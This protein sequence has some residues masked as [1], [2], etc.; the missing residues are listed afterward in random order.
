MLITTRPPRYP[1]NRFVGP[2]AAFDFNG[3]CLAEADAIS[4]AGCLAIRIMHMSAACSLEVGCSL[5]AVTSSLA[6]FMNE[7]EL[8]FVPFGKEHRF[9]QDAARLIGFTDQ[10]ATLRL[11]MR[12]WDYQQAPA[13][14]IVP[15]LT[16]PLPLARR[17]LRDINE[18]IVD[19][20]LFKQ[21]WA[22][23]QLHSWQEQGVD[24][25]DRLGAPDL[26]N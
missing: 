26:F 21:R 18:G 7:R 3:A 1:D 23:S 8:P 22:K 10:T 14:A 6:L 9:A 20:P 2:V 19:V 11:R 17:T 25:P 15:D 4:V 24:F 13:G 5:L 16:S 12:Q